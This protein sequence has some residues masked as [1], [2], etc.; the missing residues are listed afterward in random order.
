MKIEI[1]KFYKTDKGRKARVICTDSKLSVFNVICLVETSVGTETIKHVDQSG[2]GGLG[3]SLVSEWID[4]PQYFREDLPS[5]ANK[6]IAMNDN[7]QWVCFSEIPT[8]QRAFGIFL[9][10]F[11]HS[12]AIPNSHAPKWDGD[13]INSLLVFE[14]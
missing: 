14:D 9:I 12:A 7:G 10:G 8:A 2:I 6:A 13:W 5:W 4:K 3:E 11:W 1:G